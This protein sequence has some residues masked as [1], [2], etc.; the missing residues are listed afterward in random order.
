MADPD[1][2]PNPDDPKAAGRRS[3]RRAFLRGR[4]AVDALED[5][6]DRVGRETS[7]PQLPPSPAE[8]YLVSLTR[9]AMAC[10][11]EL[12]FNAGQFQGATVTALEVF[13]LLEELEQ[14]MTVYRNDSEVS[15]LNNHAAQQPQVVEEQLFGVLQ[16]AQQLFAETGGAFDITSGPLSKVWG[17]YR[18]HGALPEEAAL[19]EALSR[20]G[21]Q[22]VQLDPAHNSIFFIQR[23]VEIN[24]GSIGKGYALDRCAQE[25]EAHG[26]TE[27]L[28]HGG[29]SSVLGRGAKSGLAGWPVGVKDPL[30]PQRRVAEILL[31]DKALGTS[32]SGTQFFRHQG[33]RYGHILDPRTGWPA[34]SGVYSS[35]VVAPTAALADALATAFYVTGF[36]FA[37]SYCRQH[38]E[39]GALLITKGKG[40]ES[41]IQIANLDE[42]TLRI[43]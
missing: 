42:E 13:D 25:L 1:A 33:R 8:S 21:G 30:R 16:T 34:E 35:T 17:F 37:E 24:L 3:S 5:L 7:P 38:P 14:Q 23:G 9:R 32:G 36:D 20:V 31:K 12:Y 43:G 26:I 4:S 41:Q 15:F 19:A 27:F 29:S 22:H 39:I 2:S 6:A 11:F 10:D 18:R 28:W 40:Q